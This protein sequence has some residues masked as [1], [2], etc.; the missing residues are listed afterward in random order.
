MEET[1]RRIRAGVVENLIL[2]TMKE[3]GVLKSW[4]GKLGKH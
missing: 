2:M 3:A 1:S 4:A